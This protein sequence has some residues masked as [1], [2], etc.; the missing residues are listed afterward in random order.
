MTDI[1]V[2]DR[3]AAHLRTNAELVKRRTAVF[4]KGLGMAAPI[5]VARAENARLWDVEGREYIDFVGGLGVMNVGHQH[6]A[7]MA[8][9]RAQLERFVHSCLMVAPYEPAVEL[10]EKLNAIVPIAG[11][12][13]T[14][15]VTTG[16]EAVENVIKIARVATGRANVIA[17][18]GAFH[19]RTMLAMGL[20]GKLAPYKLGFGPFPAGIWRVPFPMPQK[21]ASTD[22]TFAALDRLFKADLDPATVAAVVFEPVQGEGGFYVAPPDFVERLRALCD[23]H[24]ILMVA[25]EIQSGFGRTGRWFAMEHYGVRPDL[26]TCAKSLAAGFPLA[27]VTGRA[28]LMD[29]PGPGG[30]G[31]TYAGNPVAVAAGLGVIEAFERDGLLQ[32]SVS[33][34]ERFMKMLASL[35][36]RRTGRPIGDIRG[37]GGMVA[38]DMVTKHGGAAPDPERAKAVVRDCLNHGLLVVTCGTYGETI[39]LL[40]PLSIDEPMLEKGIAILS[41]VLEMEDLEF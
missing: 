18:D 41:Q 31:G 24:G 3:P 13:K 23:S 7:V 21:G 2:F 11:P 15:F 32:R 17:F 22:D 12:K 28:E 30:L 20:T 8:R 33:L 37:L 1:D 27:V 6:P 5:F 26:M 36:E 39:R 10:A 40:P 29:A 38:F 9:V 35:R 19:G 25:D 34:G 16:A 4:P 14:L